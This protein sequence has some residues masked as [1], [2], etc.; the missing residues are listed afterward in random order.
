[1]IRVSDQNVLIWKMAFSSRVAGVTLWLCTSVLS[2]W[3]EFSTSA[4]SSVLHLLSSVQCPGFATW[5]YHTL[6]RH[7]VE[8]EGLLSVLHEPRLWY[9]LHTS[10]PHTLRLIS[11]CYYFLKVLKPTLGGPKNP[12]PVVSK[13]WGRSHFLIS[14]CKLGSNRTR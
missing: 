1:V 3:S 13:C 2:P 6:W 10:V 12:D 4:G 8:P 7:T 14:E 9:W 5:S 11:H